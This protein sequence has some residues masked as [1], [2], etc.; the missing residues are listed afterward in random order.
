MF[1]WFGAYRILFYAWIHIQIGIDHIQTHSRKHHFSQLTFATAA[2]P[3][4]VI[5]RCCLL[6]FI[7]HPFNRSENIVENTS[8]LL[9]TSQCMPNIRSIESTMRTFACTMVI[10]LLMFVKFH[11]RLHEK[12]RCESAGEKGKKKVGYDF[13]AQRL[14][15]FTWFIFFFFYFPNPPPIQPNV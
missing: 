9:W 13:A 6:S 14:H 3:V 1:V 7:A 4:T 8:F 10:K 2:A 12:E 5:V 11:S 15:L